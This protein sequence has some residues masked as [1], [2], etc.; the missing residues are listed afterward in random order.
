MD[1]NPLNYNLKDASIYPS[2]WQDNFNSLTSGKLH[3]PIG[4]GHDALL[5]IYI[6]F[7]LGYL[8]VS[9]VLMYHWD[10]YGMRNKMIIIAGAIFTFV[11]VVLLCLA[12]LLIN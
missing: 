12:Y 9:A 7:L 6:I 1:Y 11:S 8:I 10:A 4:L 3:L 5:G 2:G